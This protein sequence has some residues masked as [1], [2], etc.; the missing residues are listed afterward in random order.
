MKYEELK[1]LI[2]EHGAKHYDVETIEKAYKLAEK[3][4]EGQ[5]RKTG[6]AYVEH[7]VAVAGIVT[8]LGLDT[9][10][11]VAALYKLDGRCKPVSW[12]EKYVKTLL[13][14]SGALI[15]SAYCCQ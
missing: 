3:M 12:L 1:N 11:I 10:S 5:Y 15:L 4:H 8:E 14:F 13:V 6:E 9:T 7:P 2:N